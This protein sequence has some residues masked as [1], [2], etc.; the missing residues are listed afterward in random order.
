MENIT[1]LVNKIYLKRHKLKMLWFSINKQQQQELMSARSGSG[2]EETKDEDEELTEEQRSEI[3][4][5]E[6]NKIKWRELAR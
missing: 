3:A 1:E 5:D 6:K 2:N 4:L